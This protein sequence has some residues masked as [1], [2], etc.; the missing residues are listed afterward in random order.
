[1]GWIQQ[2]KYEYGMYNDHE[3]IVLR[4]YNFPLTYFDVSITLHKLIWPSKPLRAE[5]C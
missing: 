5:I 2:E 4:N 3:T 1:M